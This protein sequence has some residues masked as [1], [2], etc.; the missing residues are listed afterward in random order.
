MLHEMPLRERGAEMG[1]VRKR[2]TNAKTHLGSRQMNE[3]SWMPD[4]VE[5]S[6]GSSPRHHLTQQHKTPREN[7]SAEPTQCIRS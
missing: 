3:P 7:Y 4:S 2:H 5:A 1:D 6:F